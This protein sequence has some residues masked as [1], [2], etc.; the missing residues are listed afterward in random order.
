[1]LAQ[2]WPGKEIIVVDDGSRDKTWRSHRRSRRGGQGV[3]QKNAGASAAQSCYRLCTGDYIQWLD[4][5]DLLDPEK[6]PA[7]RMAGG[8]KF[9]RQEDAFV[10]G[11]VA[12]NSGWPCEVEC[13][14]VVGGFDAVEWL[15]EDGQNLHMANQSWLTSANW[16][17][18]RAVG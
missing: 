13:D 8:L 9:G 11:M 5:D 6:I 15:C 3:T 1:V 18:R 16:R 7:G 2:T 17:R 10:L 4:A 12:V 14:G